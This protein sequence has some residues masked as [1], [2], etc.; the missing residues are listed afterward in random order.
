LEEAFK[1][2]SDPNLPPKP[3]ENAIMYGA[4][5]R[6]YGDDLPFSAPKNF[7][8]LDFKGRILEAR[9]EIHE[10]LGECEKRPPVSGF[11]K[12]LQDR[13][14]RRDFQRLWDECDGWFAES[15]KKSG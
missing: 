10:W 9:R 3:K 13:K 1:L 14:D 11:K 15:P 6:C 7:Y 4:F 12:W 2:V 8:T 5:W